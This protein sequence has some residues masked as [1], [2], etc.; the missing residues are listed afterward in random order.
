MS[1]RHHSAAIRAHRDYTEDEKQKA[2]RRPFS[3]SKRELDDDYE[4]DYDD[5][6]YKPSE[7]I[8]RKSPHR[9]EWN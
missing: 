5:Y 7:K 8:R 3:P 2:P 1:K 4:M 9:E 6:D